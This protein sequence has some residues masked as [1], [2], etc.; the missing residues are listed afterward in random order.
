MTPLQHDGL[1][2]FYCEC[3]TICLALVGAVLNAKLEVGGASSRQR[4]CAP[5]LT[6]GFQFVLLK[7]HSSHVSKQQ[8]S[9]NIN[10]HTRARNPKQRARGFTPHLHTTPHQPGAR[11][12][13]PSAFKIGMCIYPV[14]AW[15]VDNDE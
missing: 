10:N 2:L 15:L 3:V 6:S 13:R 12:T 8:D 14:Q 9:C 11:P 7:Q 4:T 5:A 1:P